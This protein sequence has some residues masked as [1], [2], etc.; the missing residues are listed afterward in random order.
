MDYPSVQSAGNHEL[1]AVFALVS[2]IISAARGYKTQHQ[3]SLGAELA[4]IIITI[5]ADQHAALL[6]RHDDIIGATKALELEVISGEKK[7]EVVG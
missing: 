1:N 7:I 3:L 6:G 2:E 4:K 5:P